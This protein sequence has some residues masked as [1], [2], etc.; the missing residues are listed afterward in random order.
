MEVG[1]SI[2]KKDTWAFVVTVSSL[3]QTTHTVT[4]SPQLLKNLTHGNASPEDLVRMS[5]EFLLQRESNTS[6][7]HE[8]DL[9]MISGYFPEYAS[10]IRERFSA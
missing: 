1:I 9:S 5:F 3:V 6:I 10:T 7:L 4:L 2:R 8:F